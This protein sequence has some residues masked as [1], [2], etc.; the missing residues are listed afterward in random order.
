M[1][2][3]TPQ[4]AW[5]ER[6][7]RSYLAM[8]LPSTFPQFTITRL[9]LQPLAASRNQWRLTLVLSNHQARTA[10]VIT[11]QL[12][13][14]TGKVLHTTVSIEWDEVVDP[15]TIPMSDADAQTSALS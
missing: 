13:D 10:V 4:D 14:E 15:H 7:V 5:E 6:Y 2:A 9:E 8:T 1:S 3:S 11:D 12:T